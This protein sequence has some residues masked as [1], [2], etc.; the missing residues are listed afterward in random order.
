M[1]HHDRVLV[2]GWSRLQGHSYTKGDWLS[3]RFSG[4][5]GEGRFGG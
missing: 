1:Q 3:T 2:Q 4:S 5:A